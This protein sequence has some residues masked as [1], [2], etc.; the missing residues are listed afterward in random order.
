MMID[1]GRSSVEAKFEDGQ[2][3]A[4]IHRPNYPDYVLCGNHLKYWIHEWQ[5]INT[6]WTDET[7]AMLDVPTD[8]VDKSGNVMEPR[9][10]MSERFFL[11]Q[12]GAFLL[13]MAGPLQFEAWN[14]RLGDKWFLHF[15]TFDAYDPVPKLCIFGDGKDPNDQEEPKIVDLTGAVISEHLDKRQRAKMKI[16]IPG[17]PAIVCEGPN[18][19]WWLGALQWATRDKGK[20]KSMFRDLI[21]HRRFVPVEKSISVLRM[22]RRAT[23]VNIKR[24]GELKRATLA[25]TSPDGNE[26]DTF[27]SGATSSNSLTDE[28]KSKL[29]KGDWKAKSGNH[30]TS[31]LSDSPRL[32]AAEFAR[33]AGQ[34]PPR[35]QA[36][37]SS[38]PKPDQAMMLR[39]EKRGSRLLGE[40]SRAQIPLISLGLDD[41]NGTENA[42]SKA[43]ELTSVSPRRKSEKKL[44]KSKSPRIESPLAESS[45]PAVQSLSP[46]K[47]SVLAEGTDDL[48]ALLPVPSNPQKRKSSKRQENVILTEDDFATSPRAAKPDDDIPDQVLTSTSLRATSPIADDESE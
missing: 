25:D 2:L 17:K 33:Q 28:A 4:F 31:K 15:V 9:M 26:L 20:N 42:N 13:Y 46:R 47:K 1:L 7:G 24:K 32:T 6:T 14:S 36:R 48:P 29:G 10:D 35:R 39:A 12:Q 3:Y 40:D 18:I 21:K 27:G 38:A 11:R 16:E 41:A 45:A 34:S 44:A 8:V 23:E 19:Q 37:R 43:S 5:K 22:Q 30:A